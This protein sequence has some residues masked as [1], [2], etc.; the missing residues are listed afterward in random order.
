MRPAGPQAASHIPTYGAAGS[1]DEVE[2]RTHQLSLLVEINTALAGALDAESVLG[3]ILSRL[4]DRERLSHARIYRLDEP[5]GELQRVAYGGRNGGSRRMVYLRDRTL[6]A[7]AIQQKEAVYVPQVEKDPR[8]QEFDELE[9]CAYAVPLQTST[10]VLGILDVATDQPDGI[11]SVTRK[12]IDQ[13]ATQ[14][15]LA[16]DR[17][18]LY[19]QLRVSEE[20]FRSIF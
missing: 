12:L 16:L 18:E 9:R 1:G 11:R 14:A 13:V 4:A 7:W 8:C 6:L 15:A 17:S 20:R 10:R 5:A 2:A 3:P 19:K